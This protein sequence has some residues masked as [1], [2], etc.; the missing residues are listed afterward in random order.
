[1]NN[2]LYSL[3]EKDIKL[4]LIIYSLLFS[5][6]LFLSVLIILH[7][8]T[9]INSYS[10]TLKAL[11]GS[12]GFTLLASTLHYTRKIYKILIDENDKISKGDE[13]NKFLRLG[14]IIY[15]ISRPLFSIIFSLFIIIVLKLGVRI[16]TIEINGVK[17]NHTFIYTAMS[18]SFVTG[19]SVGKVID[20]LLEIRNDTI[21]KTFSK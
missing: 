9:F 19:F 2:K 10:I 15:L 12:I 3:K 11:L 17:F 5:V 13:K 1:M 16:V 14:I 18:L 4:I 21:K 6:G 7:D 20:T 8:T